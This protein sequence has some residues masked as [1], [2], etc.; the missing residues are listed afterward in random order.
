MGLVAGPTWTIMVAMVRVAA[1][2]LVLGLVCLEPAYAANECR[3]VD[4]ELTPTDKLQMVVWLED[5]AGPNV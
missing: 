1:G 2:S 3:V 5:A 4:V